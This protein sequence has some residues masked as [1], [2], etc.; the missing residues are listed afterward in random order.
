MHEAEGK[1]TRE[2][3]CLFSMFISGSTSSPLH[4][5]ATFHLICTSSSLQER[6]VLCLSSLVLVCKMIPSSTVHEKSIQGIFAQ[7]LGATQFK[8]WVAS[9]WQKTIFWC[10][11]YT[12]KGK[13][14]VIWIHETQVIV[15]KYLIYSTMQCSKKSFPTLVST[16]CNLRETPLSFVQTECSAPMTSD[17]WPLIPPS[18]EL[19]ET[20]WPFSPVGSPLICISTVLLARSPRRPRAATTPA[21]RS[22]VQVCTSFVLMVPIGEGSREHWPQCS[23]RT[24]DSSQNWRI[25]SDD[26]HL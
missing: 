4:I 26:I 14:R 7:V 5:D 21:A 18:Q 22:S 16:G 13:I 10:F 3:A 2:N 12:E 17:L 1:R 11:G 19:G 24:A 8:L 25:Q 15:I 9:S 20:W 23:T 6:P